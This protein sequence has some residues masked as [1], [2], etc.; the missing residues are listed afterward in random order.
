MKPNDLPTVYL[1][2]KDHK[3]F[4]APFQG[5]VTKPCVLIFRSKEVAEAFKRLVTPFADGNSPID[6]GRDASTFL[7]RLWQWDVDYWCVI[8]TTASAESQ[9]SCGRLSDLFCQDLESHL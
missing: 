7:Q 6:L 9:V 8:E 4:T 1:L 3:A 2:T 5:D